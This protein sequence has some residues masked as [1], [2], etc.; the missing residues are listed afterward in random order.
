MNQTLTSLNLSYNKLGE[1]VENIK[2]LSDAVKVN[3]TLTYLD[4]REN[5]LGKKGR[6]YS[7]PLGGPKDEQDSNYFGLIR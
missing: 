2:N 1:N 6:E 4:L 3:R 5:D 7:N